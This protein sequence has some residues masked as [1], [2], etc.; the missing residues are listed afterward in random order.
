MASVVERIAQGDREA[1][2]SF[3]RDYE[4]RIRA[5]TRVRLRNVDTARDLTQEILMASI[6]A[7]RRGSLRDPA[8]LGA[9]VHG[10]ARNIINSHFRTR[11]PEPVREPADYDL[12]W[13]PAER[14]ETDIVRQEIEQL[15]P[16]DRKI[17]LLTLVDGAKPNEI[18]TQLGV[19]GE[20]VRQRKSRATK[21][22]ADRLS[23][24]R[25]GKPQER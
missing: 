3:A 21:K 25:I 15:E 16:L 11:D 20:V 12:V 5:L 2:E 24:F 8:V 13:S 7:L 4:P 14:Q 19:N 10:V 9:F 22:I 23:Q 17:L 1:E 6:E 18:A